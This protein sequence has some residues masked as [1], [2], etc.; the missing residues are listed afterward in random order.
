MMLFAQ[1]K[2]GVVAVYLEGLLND[3]TS[4]C[5]L[6]C[7]SD[8]IFESLQGPDSRNSELLLLPSSS[9]AKTRN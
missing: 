5:H 1:T 7:I 4:Q 8:C 6:D 9:L 3:S 2:Q